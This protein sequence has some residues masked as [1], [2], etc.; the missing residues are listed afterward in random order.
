MRIAHINV[1]ANLSTGRIAADLCRYARAAGHKALLCYG[2]GTAP[3]DIP[4]LRI[5]DTL[6]GPANV[7]SRQSA[8]K[9]TLSAAEARLRSMAASAGVL[10]HAGL[11]RITDRSGFYSS[12]S[13]LHFIRQ[14]E[15][16]Q[17]DLVHLHNLHGYYLNLPML[18]DY[19]RE[20]DIPVVWTLHDCWAYTGH[21][22]YYH[23]A[24]QPY[25]RPEDAPDP[26]AAAA[27]LRW[28]KGCDSCP[29]KKTY[30]A[31]YVLDQSNRNYLEKWTLLTSLRRLAL[32]T[33]SEWLRQQAAQSFFSTYPIVTLPNAIDLSV[34]TPCG[35]ERTMQR[36]AMRYGLDKLGDRRLVLSV[37][38]V[39]D[40]RKGLEHLMELS[41]ALGNGYCVAAVGLDEKQMKAL[42]EGMLGI[43]RTESVEELCALYT[44]ADLYVSMSQ[45]ETMGMTLLEAMACGTQVLCYDSTAMPELLT[46][47]CG[48]SVPAGDIRAFASAVRHMCDQPK[49]PLACMERAAQY[50][51]EK[52]Y[53]GYLEL[54]R[55]V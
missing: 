40:E 26:S 41:K 14:L 20:T 48:E 3:S 18:I 11:S 37:A 2:R 9:R 25:L 17:P 30:P 6:Q 23:Y 27:C 29:L 45:G 53:Q 4:C 43:P 7:T 10:V 49:D 1:T 19:L 16:F 44:I 22:A 51:P 31:S 32:A 28:Q 38:A 12:H 33:P 35:D 39:W 50:T 8:L 15:K 13:T 21:C 46:P 55:Q 34:F 36:T 5:G 52:C 47:E 42:P 54:Y 24:I